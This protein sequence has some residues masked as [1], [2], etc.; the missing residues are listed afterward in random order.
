MHYVI[1]RQN[2]LQQSHFE[3]TVANT[4]LIQSTNFYLP[5]NIGSTTIFRIT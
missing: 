4:G 1:I 2:I 3:I 5:E